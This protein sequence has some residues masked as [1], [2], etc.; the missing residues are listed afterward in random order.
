MNVELNINE[1][2]KSKFCHCITNVKQF[3]N[4]PCW[5]LVQRLIKPYK[6]KLTFHDLPLEMY[7]DNSKYSLFMCTFLVGYHF[8][9]IVLMI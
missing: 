2:K 3:E 8:I 7:M 5:L 1:E 4:K 9:Y 6:N